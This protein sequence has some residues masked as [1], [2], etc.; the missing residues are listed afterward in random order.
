[1]RVKVEAEHVELMPRFSLLLLA[2]SGV[3][4]TMSYSLI[5][6]QF[7]DEVLLGDFR[8]CD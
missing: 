5:R 4:W 6:R 7:Q 3:A 1:M 8:H 2:F